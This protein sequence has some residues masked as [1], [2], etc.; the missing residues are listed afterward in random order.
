MRLLAIA[1]GGCLYEVF[2]K[3]TQN[4]KRKVVGYFLLVPITEPWRAV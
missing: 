1:C 2:A 4:G 3:G